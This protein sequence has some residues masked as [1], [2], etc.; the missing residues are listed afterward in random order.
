MQKPSLA[1]W[2]VFSFDMSKILT[3]VKSMTAKFII[4]P[5]EIRSKRSSY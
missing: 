3:P 5:T 2:E 1:F 4:P